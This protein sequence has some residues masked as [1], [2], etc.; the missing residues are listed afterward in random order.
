MSAQQNSAT[1]TIKAAVSK[2]QRM[3]QICCAAT[4]ADSKNASSRLHT[5][6]LLL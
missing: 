4:K 6:A 2:L 5:L 1:H 3:L